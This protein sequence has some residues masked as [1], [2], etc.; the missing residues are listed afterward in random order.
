LAISNY[1]GLQVTLTQHASHGLDF[2][3]GYTYSHSLNGP[4]FYA[5]MPF[6]QNSYDLAAEYGN[7][8][9]NMPNRFT[10]SI[11]YAVPGING[12]GQMLKGWHANSVVTLESGTSWSMV[13]TSDDISLTG[14]LQDRWDIYGSPSNFKTTSSAFIYCT[15]TATT[16]ANCTGP[17]PS[18]FLSASQAASDYSQCLSHAGTLPVGPQGQTGVQSLVTF[19][20]YASGNGKS[21]IVPPSLGT[22][23]TSARSNFQGPGLYEWDASIF[24]NF[25]IERV[26]AEFRAEFFNVL[27]HPTLGNP[28]LL[29]GNDVSAPGVFGCGCATSD[30]T[31]SNPLYGSGGNR[32]IQLGLKLSF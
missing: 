24:K 7:S 11:T 19:G 31:A 8:R 1:N 28:E 22:F 13:D 2:L 15:G 21:V 5:G 23:G 18:G 17:T 29:G 6:P 32:A 25:T 12:F 30:V 20:C 3:A 16:V 26:R 10:F 27:N 4:D 9:F 14:E